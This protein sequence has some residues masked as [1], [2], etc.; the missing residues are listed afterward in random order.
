M[1][2]IVVDAKDL[3]RLSAGARQELIALVGLRSSGVDELEGP[4][5]S[6]NADGDDPYPLSLR[7]AKAL[8]QGLSE[9]SRGMLRLFCKN[10]DGD[11]GRV[12][13]RELLEATGHADAEHLQKAI[14]GITRRLRTVTGHREAWLLDWENEW[15]EERR[16][17]FRSEYFITS[18]SIRSLGQVLG[19]EPSRDKK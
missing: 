15:D 14:S 18:P 13:M 6:W 7:E 2:G 19:S 3:E 10:S 5:G 4:D 9:S 17:H 11:V 8:V 16:V 1:A 12:S